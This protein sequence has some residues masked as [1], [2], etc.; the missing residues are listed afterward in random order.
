MSEDELRSGLAG[1]GL[2]DFVI[3]AVVS[4]KVTQAEG[5]YDII[6]GDVERLAG[7]PPKPL[8]EVLASE[9]AR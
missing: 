8:S 7:T 5:A 1:A 3:D 6:T 9:F 2:P 4:M